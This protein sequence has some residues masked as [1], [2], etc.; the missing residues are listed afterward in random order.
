M[1]K[2]TN[3]QTLFKG[4]LLST[5][6]SNHRNHRHNKQPLQFLSLSFL[7]FF[8]S[9]P[10]P[11]SARPAAIPHC[12]KIAKLSVPHRCTQ[13]EKGF[14]LS[15]DK[16]ACPA[17]GEGCPSCSSENTC[18]GGCPQGKTWSEAAK[19][20]LKCSSDCVKCTG[21]P[22][23][24]LTSCQKCQ[25]D[26]L[27]GSI[28]VEG[29]TYKTVCKHKLNKIK[30]ILYVGLLSVTILVSICF[31]IAFR[32]VIKK[33]SK[34]KADSMG[35]G[36]PGDKEMRAGNMSLELSP[37]P[38]NKFNPFVNIPKNGSPNSGLPQQPVSSPGQKVKPKTAFRV[39]STNPQPK[40]EVKDVTQL[41][42]NDKIKIALL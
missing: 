27:T 15:N 32:Y 2:L 19:K 42:T 31:V 10:P 26:F 13:C 3:T 40:P 8:L 17:C 20:C 21:V 30:I 12:L 16:L 29:S 4:V 22:G 38:I 41:S 39:N 7:L 33:G 36:S 14:F 28:N 25:K 18:E 1:V 35:S 37:S 9:L 24:P 23:H 11:L 34:N 5:S 6:P